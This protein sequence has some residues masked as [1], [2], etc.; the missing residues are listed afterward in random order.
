MHVGM[1]SRD[2]LAC[3]KPKPPPQ[4]FIIPRDG[5]HQIFRQ[6]LSILV[7]LIFFF[8]GGRSIGGM[9]GGIWYLWLWLEHW[10]DRGHFLPALP[11]RQTK[12]VGVFM[13]GFANRCPGDEMF[14]R[15]STLASSFLKPAFETIEVLKK[16]PLFHAGRVPSATC[17]WHRGA[18]AG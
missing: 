12:G 8:I 16:R 11:N 9:A 18:A 3:R 7:F 13:A 10:Q 14:P 17:Y 2:F 5:T 1:D 4:K 6:G 15:S